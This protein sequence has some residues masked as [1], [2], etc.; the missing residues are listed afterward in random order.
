MSMFFSSSGSEEDFS[1]EAFR[2]LCQRVRTAAADARVVPEEAVEMLRRV[3]E[4]IVYGDAEHGGEEESI[5]VSKKDAHFDV[6]CERN[7][8]GSCV[9]IA[10]RSNS[11]EARIQLLQTLSILIQNV[12]NTVFL[13]YML[14]NNYIN[15]VIETLVTDRLEESDLVD[16]F[17]AFCKALALRLNGRTVQFFFANQSCTYCPLFEKCLFF[18]YARDSMVRTSAMAVLLHF[19]ALGGSGPT[20]ESFFALPV[21]VAR[22]GSQ[23]LDV[24]AGSEP[25]TRRFLQSPRNARRIG[26][27][28]VFFLTS[29]HLRVVDACTR[30]RG[31]GDAARDLLGDVEEALLL[32]DDVLATAAPIEEL[33]AALRD[34]VVHGFLGPALAF[35]LADVPPSAAERLEGARGAPRDGAAED[36]PSAEEEDGPGPSSAARAQQKAALY[37]AGALPA[38][39][40][41][42][43]VLR[44][45]DAGS[46]L[47]TEVRALLAGGGGPEGA[48]GA[49]EGRGGAPRGQAA[50]EAREG[51]V[52]E[53]HAPQESEQPLRRPE[54]E[55][56]PLQGA[57]QSRVAQTLQMPQ[58]LQMPQTPQMPQKPQ[59]PQMPQRP[60]MPQMPQ[61]LQTTRKEN[62]QLQS[63]PDAEAARSQEPQDS[64][65][66]GSPPVPRPPKSSA[67]AAGAPPSLA[68]LASDGFFACLRGDRGARL[69]SGALLLCHALLLS[70][71]ARGPLLAPLHER[72][73]DDSIASSGAA[74]SASPRGAE[75]RRL[76]SRVERRLSGMAAAGPHWPAALRSAL[77]GAAGPKGA[78]EEGACS[79]AALLLLLLPQRGGEGALLAAAAGDALAGLGGSAGAAL[80]EAWEDELDAIDARQTAPRDPAL[81]LMDAAAPAAGAFAA[82]AGVPA[83]R[84]EGDAAAARRLRP[85]RFALA[86][87]LAQCGGGAAARGRLRE[88]AA[89]C[90]GVL[91]VRR[92][93]LLGA[94]A[95]A[96]GVH[97][98]M[99]MPMRGRSVIGC[100]GSVTGGSDAKGRG[101]AL[102]QVLYLVLDEAWILLAT[103][104]AHSVEHGNLVCAAPLRHCDAS[105]DGDDEAALTVRIRSAA[106]FI[107]GHTGDIAPQ[108]E[109]GPAAPREEWTLSLAFE[110]P[111][112]ASAA[113]MHLQGC[114]ERALAGLAGQLRDKVRAVQ[115]LA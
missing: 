57:E 112:T 110:M 102:P 65:P 18:L 27:F 33:H 79:L 54:E 66:G 89:A 107:A 45:C 64:A 86:A 67:A 20:D 58:M 8:L 31:R 46:V 100:G 29:T 10:V 68:S 106:A 98:Q 78:D 70:D 94:L 104:D 53:A 99:R 47:A 34:A 37:R 93:A 75:L 52:R 76:R 87:L 55:D 4:F 115:D 43:A 109:P 111:A 24:D 13:F 11:S 97:G 90:A 23:P 73:S 92:Q 77:R 40:L 16:A 32:V 3:G 26:D 19:L 51:E 9:E 60:Q 59:M 81:L 83:P 105:A 39:S 7:T 101:K 12:Q 71:A 103:P 62:A 50:E 25:L 44:C 5:D 69:S 85:R 95:L 42:A 21:P 48:A 1:V 41:G 96:E 6:F 35:P 114:R 49:E 72:R 2:G 88:A 84:E 38:M 14:S 36:G 61:T 63:A 17:I 82:A 113:R 56:A 91:R 28:L 22:D 15:Q 30:G 80:L 108:A 74:P